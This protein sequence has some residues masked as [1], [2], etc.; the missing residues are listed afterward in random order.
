MKLGIDVSQHQQTWDELRG[1]VEFAEEAGFESAWVFDHFKPLYADPS[2]PCMEGWTLLAALAASTSRIRLG[3]LVTGVTY[4][5]PSVLAAEAV[6]VDHVSRGRLEL[7]MGAAWFEGEHDQLGIEFPSTRERTRRLEEALQVVKLLMT[8]DGASFQG[9][10][11]E[12]SGASYNPKP[13]Q[14]PHPPIWVGASGE[15]VT[16]PIAARHA[17]VWHT[18][19]SVDALKRKARI[20]NEAAQKAGRDPAAITHSTMLSISEPWDE[21]ER[22]ARADEEAGFSYLIVSWPGE[23]R[24]RVEEFLDEVGRELI[25]S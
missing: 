16:I 12:L 6:T 20:L 24:A 19:G 2:G 4:R 21:V 11:Y 18:F 25:A 13:V 1:R 17:D 7:G 8:E 14:K 15:R 3:A 5:H 22:I 9:R 10:H 23:G